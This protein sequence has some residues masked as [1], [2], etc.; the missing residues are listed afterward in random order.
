MIKLENLSTIELIGSKHINGKKNISKKNK[1]FIINNEIYNYGQLVDMCEEELSIINDLPCKDDATKKNIRKIIEKLDSIPE[2]V[3][4]RVYKIK[5][6][7]EFNSYKS[8]NSAC[9]NHLLYKPNFLYSLGGLSPINNTLFNDDKRIDTH[10]Y[11]IYELKQL[12]SYCDI[13]GTNLFKKYFGNDIN[14]EEICKLIKSI[15]IYNEQLN[16]QYNELK[17]KEDY[18]GL[19]KANEIL[20]YHLIKRQINDVLEAFYYSEELVWGKVYDEERM[21]FERL[22]N[23]QEFIIKDNLARTI[24]N[25]VS[26]DEAEKGIVKTKALDRF[27]IK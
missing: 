20:K 22:L 9:V 1:E 27:I 12:L 13:N 21:L 26:Q 25:Y 16:R 10:F 19:F 6:D 15:E 8:D 2:V 3:N 7:L 5:N 24:A 14:D 17:V 18:T 23:N 4:P 11:N